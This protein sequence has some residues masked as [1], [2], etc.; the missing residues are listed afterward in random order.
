VGLGCLNPNDPNTLFISTRYDPRAVQPGVFDSNPPYSTRR[1][2]WKGTTTN[3]GASFT[4]TQVTRNSARDNFRPIMPSWYPGNAALVW[5][6]GTYFSAHSYDAA[7]VGILD[8]RAETRDLGTF[9][10]ATTANTTLADGSPLVTGPGANQWHER[11]GSF[12]G[13]TVL[14]S[15][16]IAAE[17]AAAIKTT[18]TAPLAGTYDVWVNFWGTPTAD[19]RISA[20]LSSNGMKIL[21]QLAGQQVEPGSHTS[22]LVLTN[23]G[24][25]FLYQ[26]Y[27]GRVTGPTFEVFIDDRAIATGTAGTLV[28]SSARTWYDGISYARID[29]LRITADASHDLDTQ[30]VTLRWNSIPPE[31]SLSLPT[32]SIQTKSALTDADWITIASGLPSAGS[33]TAWTDTS[34][35]NGAAFYRITS[36]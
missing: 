17:N 23:S 18:V 22:A 21:R 30:S 9:V 12:N 2:I 4:W 7:I 34:A 5:F 20:G 31:S 8:R 15:A 24:T 27:V 1:E 32:Y 16:D 10:D 13:G 11:A 26:A 28:G 3:H 29:P 35:T 36:P 25:N 33:T 19:W 6:R 14:A